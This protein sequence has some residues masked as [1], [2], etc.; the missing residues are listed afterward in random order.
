MFHKVQTLIICIT[1]LIGIPLAGV[2]A[3][4]NIFNQDSSPSH[5][6]GICLHEHS[7]I[8]DDTFDKVKELG[9]DCV[10]I[11]I[12]WHNLEPNRDEYDAE[13]INHMEKAISKFDDIGVGLFAVMTH[14]PGWAKSLYNQDKTAFWVELEEYHIKTAELWGD[15]IYYYQLENELNHPTRVPYFDISDLPTYL[16]HARAGIDKEDDKFKTVMNTICEFIGWQLEMEKWLSSGGKKYIDIIGLDMYPLTWGDPVTMWSPLRQA[17]ALVKNSNTAWSGKD[18]IIAETGFSTYS[19]AHTEDNQKGFIDVAIKYLNNM[20]IDNNKAN[21]R[22]VLMIVWYELYDS[23]S[24]TNEIEDNFGIC[25]RDGSKKVGFDSLKKQVDNIE[26]ITPFSMGVWLPLAGL[27]ILIFIIIL[28]L[29]YFFYFRKKKN[30]N[31]RKSPRRMTKISNR[32][33]SK[34]LEKMIN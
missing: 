14:A 4:P 8:I 1:L 28:G 23:N 15:K 12:S 30:K 24:N 6:W 20:V 7:D 22:K 17:L 27:E 19:P 18:I 33:K 31:R 21:E 10:R 13:Y 3:S 34:R 25:H 32:T 11:D 29:V 26:D 5:Q 16:K 9:V 2:S